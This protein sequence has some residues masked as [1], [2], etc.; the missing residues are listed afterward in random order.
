MVEA[1]RGHRHQLPLRADT[2]EKHNELQF[3]EHH[4]I[5]A[6]SAKGLVEMPHQVAHE[7]QIEPGFDLAIKVI[8]R[9]ERFQ[10]DDARLKV[11]F[12]LA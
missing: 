12:F 9:H 5:D 10:G 7:G 11:A 6:R 1:H 2:L 8:F 4:R 3:E